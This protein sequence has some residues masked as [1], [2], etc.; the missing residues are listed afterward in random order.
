MQFGVRISLD[1]SPVPF[2]NYQ[3]SSVYG[4]VAKYKPPVKVL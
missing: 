3:M 1:V 4:I 2:A